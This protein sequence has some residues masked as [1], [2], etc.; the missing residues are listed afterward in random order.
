[1]RLSFRQGSVASGGGWDGAKSLE[2]A[3]LCCSALATL[4]GSSADPW[5]LQ[6]SSV[7]VIDLRLHAERKD[8]LK[9]RPSCWVALMECILLDYSLHGCRVMTPWEQTLGVY[10]SFV[11]N[12]WLCV[13]PEF[14]PGVFPKASPNKQGGRRVLSCHSLSF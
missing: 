2:W 10:F 6:L 5:M 1:M 13:P 11:W 14:P 7:S 3:Q 12:P 9:E 8:K 4:W